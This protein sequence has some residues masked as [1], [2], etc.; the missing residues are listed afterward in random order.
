MF[1][2]PPFPFVTERRA[3]LE[4]LLGV[5]V[6]TPRVLPGALVVWR[7]PTKAENVA[8]PDA[9]VE[10]DRREAGRSVIVL[11]RRSE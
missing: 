5:L 3:E 7:T 4:R 6:S 1:V 11:Y 9:L 10:I 8:V 2:D